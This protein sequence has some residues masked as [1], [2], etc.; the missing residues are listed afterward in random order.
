M[1]CAHTHADMFGNVAF[2]VEHSL[3]MIN[4][5]LGNDKYIDIQCMLETNFVDAYA[6]C[7]ATLQY[8]GAGPTSTS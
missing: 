3:P 6:R 8:V 5:A 2:G 1:C 4:N 7:K